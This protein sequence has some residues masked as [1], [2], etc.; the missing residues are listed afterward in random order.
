MS[1]FLQRRSTRRPLAVAA[2]NREIVERHYQHR[3]IRR[4]T[5]AFERDHDRRVALVN[6]AVN[7]FKR[8]LPDASSGRVAAHA[9]RRAGNG[10]G[11]IGA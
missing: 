8:H 11:G 4:I 5:E 7:A 1:Q 10:A 9:R 6:Q 2:F 3:G